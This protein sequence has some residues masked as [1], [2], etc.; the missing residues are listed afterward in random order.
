[1]MTST[2]APHGAIG[3]VGFDG[4]DTL[5]KSEDFYRTAEQ[6]YL[7]I[8]ARYIDVHDTR[9]ARHLLEVQ[10]RNLGVFGYGVKGMTLSMVEAAIEITNQTISARDLQ[11][12][13]DIGHATLRHPVELIDGVREAVTEIAREHPVVLITKGDLFHQEAKIKLANLRDLFPRIEIVSEKD[14]E[15]YARV[16]AEFDLPIQRFC[17]IGNS[18]RSDIE[19]VITLGGWGI[20]TP[21]AVTWAHETQHGVADDEPRMVDAPTAFEWPQALRTIE[22]KAAQA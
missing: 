14:P 22:A 9:T 1:M 18:L 20:H 4:D 2:P 8:L 6:D 16:L 13:L 11:Q 21:Y 12:M 7:D 3:L 5:W 15:T 17:M 10:Q 19:P